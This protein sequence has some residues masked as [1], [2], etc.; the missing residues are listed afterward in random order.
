MV[1][2]GH[3]E[4]NQSIVAEFTK[5]ARIP[6]GNLPGLSSESAFQLMLD[7]CGVGPGD[8]VLDVGCGAGS[9]TCAFATQADHVTGIDLT[10]AML[11]QARQLQA[12]RN[13]TNISWQVGD[14]LPLPFADGIFSI[15]A[16]RHTFH[17]FVDPLAVLREMRRVCRTNGRILVVDVAPPADKQEAFNQMEKLR[18][19]SHVRALTARELLDL[20][21]TAGLRILRAESYK[22]EMQLEP[23]L[24]AS[25]PNSGDAQRIRSLFEGDLLT[26]SLGLNSR[27]IGNDLHFA[28]P[29]TMVLS[30]GCC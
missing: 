18:D 24:A 23:L 16:T 6:T 27:C 1:A 29:I 21:E 17:H 11:E 22:L 2:S 30:E 3:P 28:Y 7:M 19:P 8:Y 20:H 13:L 9:L 12:T 15:V 26:G 4:Q 25:F 14:A 10:S 5:Q